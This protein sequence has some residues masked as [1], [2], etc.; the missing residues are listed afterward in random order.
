MTIEDTAAYEICSSVFGKLKA[1]ELVHGR[2]RAVGHRDRDGKRK[3]L[4]MGV[5]RAHEKGVNGYCSRRQWDR[6]GDSFE[7]HNGP[8]FRYIDPHNMPE[9]KLRCPWVKMTNPEYVA[10]HDQEWGRSVHDDD[11]HF[12]MLTLEGAQAGL[13]WETVLKKRNRYRK[14]FA[15]FNPEKVARFDGTRIQEILKDP[16]IIRNRL[17]VESTVSNAKAFLAVQKEF[18]SFDRYIWGFVEGKTIYSSFKKLSDYPAKTLL[19]DTASKDLKKRG[20]RFVGSTIIY[21]YMQ[22]AGM[23]NDHFTSCFRYKELKKADR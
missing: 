13:S 21:A 4:E 14:V 23:V 16:G 1:G 20:F 18:G 15:R 19:S 3:R 8:A 5:V 2:D 9:K 17:K 22:A 10:Y 6:A 12:E 11:R 7:G